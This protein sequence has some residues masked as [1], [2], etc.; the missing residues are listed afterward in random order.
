MSNHHAR[1]LVAIALTLVLAKACATASGKKL[2][3]IKL[4]KLY[5]I[6]GK[7]T[8]VRWQNNYVIIGSLTFIPDEKTG[9]CLPALDPLQPMLVFDATH[10]TRLP[11]E[12]L[13]T[14]A[15]EWQPPGSHRNFYPCNDEDRYSPTAPFLTNELFYGIDD[16][17]FVVYNANWREKYRV[18]PAGADWWDA[19][20]TSNRAGTR[21][22]ILRPGETLLA[23][24]RNKL[25]PFSNE[26]HTEKKVIT[27]FSVQDG[28][29]LFEH[30]WRDPPAVAPEERHNTE[31]VAFSDDGEMLAVLTEDR[32]LQVFQIAGG[33]E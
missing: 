29:K 20:I 16:K 23:E 25:T 30:W 33:N 21:F 7:R 24:I 27:V 1:K 13:S 15:L 2:W 5:Q 26:I 6:D 3:D 10:S 4:A 28:K 12:V 14:F 11:K 9:K 32:E 18:S 19:C 17:Y 22:A 8:I 31:R